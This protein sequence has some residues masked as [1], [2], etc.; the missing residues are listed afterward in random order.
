MLITVPH[1]FK[2]I[3]YTIGRRLLFQLLSMFKISL[4]GKQLSSVATLS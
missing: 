1:A 4:E 2:Q 3:N